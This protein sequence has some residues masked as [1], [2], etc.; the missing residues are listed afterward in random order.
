MKYLL[1]I[2]VLFSSF[3]YSSIY[4]ICDEPYIF[5]P[6]KEKR[7]LIQIEDSSVARTN[8]RKQRI[9]AGWFAF[10]VRTSNYDD[11]ITELDHYRFGLRTGKNPI[12][13]NSYFY[14][15]DRTTLRLKKYFSQKESEQSKCNVVSN[16][17]F[18]Y[19]KKDL[20]KIAGGLGRKSAKEHQKILDK[21][22][23]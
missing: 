10:G 14:F 16:A 15:I 6:D 2:L 9:L 11:L 23:I 18:L 21:R 19:A 7:D 12:Y 8:I 5:Y 17:E 20:E 3:S 22:K 4:L 1:S 13:A